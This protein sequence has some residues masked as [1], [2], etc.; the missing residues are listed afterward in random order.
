MAEVTD[1][2]VTWRSSPELLPESYQSRCTRGYYNLGV[3]HGIPGIIYFLGQVSATNIVDQERCHRL[4]DGAMGWLISQQ[5]PRTARSRFS[6]WI[7]PG[8]EP[9]DSRLGWCYGDLGILAVL[10]Q[11]ARHADRRDW[12]EFAHD[13]LDHC[14]AWPAD[15][16]GV[17]DAPLCHGAA[18]VAHIFNRIYQSEGDSRCLTAALAWYKR[19]LAMRQPGTGVAGFTSFT[20]PDPSGP[21]VWEANPGFVDG[22]IGIALALLA[23]MTPVEPRWDRSMLLSSIALT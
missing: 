14:L 15:R 8:E 22:A 16:T 9:S 12:Q 4:L 17:V 10:L 3:A 21:I 6:S 19:A 20:A 13:L 11:V 5:R 23:A 7:L 18:G 1:M 2:G